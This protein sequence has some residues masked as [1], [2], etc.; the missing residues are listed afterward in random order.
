MYMPQWS[1]VY[2]QLNQ[3]S[4]V[5]FNYIYST[6]ITKTIMA[7]VYKHSLVGPASSC[8]KR[9]M[10]CLH[11]PVICLLQPPSHTPHLPRYVSKY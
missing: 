4:Q 9:H 1:G 7:R 5:H 3:G 8:L 6:D 11:Q 2:R 10:Y